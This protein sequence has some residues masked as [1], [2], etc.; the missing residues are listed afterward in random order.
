MKLSKRT[1]L[2]MVHIIESWTAAEIDRVLIHLNITVA[3]DSNGAD[4][5]RS[6]K[7]NHILLQIND[8]EDVQSEVINYIIDDFSSKH[9]NEVKPDPFFYDEEKSF[10][11]LFCEKYPTLA[12]SL[13]RDGF[14]L[15]NKMIAPLLPEEL[16]NANV[17]NELFR[18]LDKYQ[19]ATTKGHLEQAIENHSIGNWAGANS[20][21]RPF[22]ESLL[23]E[24]CNKLIPL[25]NC[26]S[27]ADALL[28]L[29][30]P[31]LISPVFLSPDLN[32]VSNPGASND[33]TYI[34]GLMK[35]LHPQG[36]HPGLSDEEDSTFR[37]HTL[38]VFAR[39]VLKRLEDRA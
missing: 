38:I 22:L 39:Y 16:V 35:R 8:N 29:A 9:E 13:K 5:S 37:Y 14:T 21:F 7:A 3:K 23:M 4:L 28:W 11:D 18:L 24:I 27:Y 36:S 34:S 19:F 20:Q 15:K 32:E 6:K 33:K 25:K 1:N 12:N 31:T 17:E 10:D 30:T 2:A 26:T